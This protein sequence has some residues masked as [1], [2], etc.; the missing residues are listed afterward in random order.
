MEEHND[1]DV[2]VTKD[3]SSD[4]TEIIGFMQ[5]QREMNTTMLEML[6]SIRRD[7]D[8]RPPARDVTDDSVELHVT[9]DQQTLSDKDDEDNAFADLNN[10][11]QT[12]KGNPDGGDG[13]G[14][15]EAIP[16]SAYR[17]LEEQIEDIV[18][19]PIETNLATVVTNTW[20][21]ARLAR[22][23]KKDLLEDI[24]IPSNCKTLKS[25]ELN[26]DISAK[27]GE[28]AVTKDKAAQGRQNDLTR[29]AIP[30]YEAVGALAK[31]RADMPTCSSQQVLASIDAIMPKLQKS[32]KVLNYTFTET[33]C[34]QSFDVCDSLGKQ[35][36]PFANSKSST[37]HLFDDEGIK[38]MKTELRAL[39][40]KS[41]NVQSSYKSRGGYQQQGKKGGKSNYNSSYKGNNSSYSGNNNG[42]RPANTT[43]KKNQGQQ[44]K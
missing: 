27:L 20:G 2:V 19:A 22:E 31:L 26:A 29:A 13:A 21:K 9:S 15:A 18:G 1:N 40:E 14:N 41:K 36:K 3:A 33:S 12:A 10:A 4:E 16:G 38:K 23:R 28:N 17:E 8:S 5:A 7:M 25:A 42:Y 37:E 34:K 11:H 6:K 35:F 24:K 43:F 39:S 44:K 30:I 32:L